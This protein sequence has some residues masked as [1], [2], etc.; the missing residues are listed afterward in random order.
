MWWVLEYF[1]L[2]EQSLTNQPTKPLFNISR[3][4]TYFFK[5]QEPLHVE[6]EVLLKFKELNI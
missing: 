6:L 3:E 5:G 1:C 4:K 2:L